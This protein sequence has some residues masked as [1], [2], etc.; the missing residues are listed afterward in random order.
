MITEAELTSK[1]SEEIVRIYQEGGL[2]NLKDIKLTSTHFRNISG[3]LILEMGEKGILHT[4]QP[5]S[6]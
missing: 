5:T 1:S 6:A 4:E 3:S 2:D